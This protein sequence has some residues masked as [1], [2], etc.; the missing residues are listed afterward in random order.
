MLRTTRPLLKSYTRPTNPNPEDQRLL[1]PTIQFSGRKRPLVWGHTQGTLLD[2]AM[3]AILISYVKH[4]WLA[5]M[6]FATGNRVCGQCVWTPIVSM[7]LKFTHICTFGSRMFIELT[8]VYMHSVILL[9]IQATR[10]CN[11]MWM[12]SS[13]RLEENSKKRRFKLRYLWT[14]ANRPKYHSHSSH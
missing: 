4:G 12:L 11:E 9:M 8:F 1:E 5:R 14:P 10:I 13:I 6:Y 2:L 3:K 7:F